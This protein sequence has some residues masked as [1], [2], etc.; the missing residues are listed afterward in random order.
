MIRRARTVRTQYALALGHATV[1]SL[2]LYGY[3][4]LRNHSLVNS[5]LLWNLLLSWLPLLLALWLAKTLETRLWSSWK[6]LAISVAWLLFLPNSFYMISDYIHLQ[7]VAHADILFDAVLF[8]SFIYSGVV[9]GF[10]SLYVIHRLLKQRFSARQAS[11]TIA[12]TLLLC[13]FA[14]YLGRDLRWNSWDILINPGGLLFDLSDRILH[15]AAYPAM[16]LTVATF[17]VLLSSLYGL[18][19]RGSQLLRNSGRPNLL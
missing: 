19:W 1:V 15:P 3:G 14:I 8:T 10:S 18:V 6:A 5:Y 13:S 11:G 7:D 9:L 4:A 12:L 16:F 17:F 2:G